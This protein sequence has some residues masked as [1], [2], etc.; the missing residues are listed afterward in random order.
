MVYLV[1]TAVVIVLLV[2]N[3]NGE[4]DSLSPYFDAMGSGQRIYY[5]WPMRA[6]TTGDYFWQSLPGGGFKEYHA[7]I[8]WF[9]MVM[10]AAIALVIICGSMYLSWLAIGRRGQRTA[11]EHGNA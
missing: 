10:D 6:Y 3:L 1:P 2:L 4:E 7:G 5:G 11:E 8:Q 9:G